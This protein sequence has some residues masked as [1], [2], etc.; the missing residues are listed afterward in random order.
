[1]V[2]S[3]RESFFL[4]KLKDPWLILGCLMFIASFV[5]VITFSVKNTDTIS[6]IVNALSVVGYICLTISFKNEQK[7][8]LKERYSKMV[9]ITNV[10]TDD[11]PFLPLSQDSVTQAQ[12]FIDSRVQNIKDV[13]TSAE[14]HFKLLKHLVKQSPQEIHI[15]DG[16]ELRNI[17]IAHRTIKTAIIRVFIEKDRIDLFTKLHNLQQSSIDLHTAEINEYI[18]LVKKYQKY[19]TSHI[20]MEFV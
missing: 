14:P 20:I 17:Q 3:W 11:I 7:Q 4:L 19:V 16:D 6:G 10:T 18:E 12:E 15:P 9:P 13:T 8:K 1:M 2:E 5:V